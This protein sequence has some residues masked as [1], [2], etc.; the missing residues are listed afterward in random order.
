MPTVRR[1]FDAKNQ[2][3]E[4]KCEARY[5]F[6]VQMRCEVLPSVRYSITQHQALRTLD[7]FDLNI[8]FLNNAVFI[9]LP[10]IRSRIVAR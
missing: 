5:S 10:A 7:E 4:A 3:G 8:R 9:R 2:T 6:Y 1:P